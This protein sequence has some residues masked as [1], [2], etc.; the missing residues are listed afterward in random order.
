M[1]ADESEHHAIMTVIKKLTKYRITFLTVIKS[2]TNLRKVLSPCKQTDAK[3]A[4]PDSYWNMGLLF[5][6]DSCELLHVFNLGNVKFSA[7]LAWLNLAT[8]NVEEEITDALYGKLN[9]ITID[10][11]TEIIGLKQL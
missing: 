2:D 8:H 1:I 9:S 10:I 5:I 3:R 4:S 6:M 11:C 7:H